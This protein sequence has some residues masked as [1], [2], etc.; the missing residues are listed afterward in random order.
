[1]QANVTRIT[2]DDTE[3]LV[4]EVDVKTIYDT[5]FTVKSNHFILVPG[6]LEISRI[7]LNSRQ[8]DRHEL[9]NEHDVVGRYFMEHPHMVT[10]KLHLFD[11]SQTNRPELPCLDWRYIKGAKAR[12]RLERP[13]NGIKFAYVTGAELQRRYKLL[14][15]S[16]HFRTLAPVANLENYKSLKLLVSNMRGISTLVKQIRNDALPDNIGKHLGNVFFHPVDMAKILYHQL[17]LKPKQLELFTQCE[18]IPNA[19]SRVVLDYDHRDKLGVPQIKL[20]W[21]LSLQDK[22]SIRKSQQLLGDHFQELGIGKLEPAT[23]LLNDDPDDWCPSMIGGYHHLGTTR[24][25]TDPKFSVVD[26]D[27]RV[28]SVKNLYITGTSVFPTGGYANPLLTGVALSLRTADHVAHLV[29]KRLEVAVNLN[30]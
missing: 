11:R 1:L 19:E 17:V 22:W 16:T 24:M 3:E 28:H 23:W 5:C 20:N 30:N 18:Q 14:N 15:F 6:A 27:G 7:L 8:G 13:V 26:P 2:L 21:K 25:G 4:R 9:G 12:L 10:G 29:E